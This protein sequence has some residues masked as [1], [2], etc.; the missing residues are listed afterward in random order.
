[1][2]S[3]A[4][5]TGAI[6]VLIGYGGL[7][8]AFA[9]GYMHTSSTLILAFLNLLTGIGNCSAFTAAMNAQAKSWGGARVSIGSFSLITES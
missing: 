2:I 4:M 9:E 6:L 7:S 3:S 1:M 8:A 5:I